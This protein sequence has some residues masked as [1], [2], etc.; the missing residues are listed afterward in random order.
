MYKELPKIE[1]FCEAG[2]QEAGA[3]G[4]GAVVGCPP[5]QLRR[6]VQP[7]RTPPRT[8]AGTAHAHATNPPTAPQDTCSS[9]C[10]MTY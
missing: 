10:H 2:R 3:G 8:V 6:Y 7:S 5:A 4:G 9:D 1:S